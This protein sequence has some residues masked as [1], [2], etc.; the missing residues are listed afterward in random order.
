MVYKQYTLHLPAIAPVSHVVHG[1]VRHVFSPDSAEIQDERETVHLNVLVTT[2]Q[3][4][5]DRRRT[6]LLLYGEQ[7]AVFICHS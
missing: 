6:Y 7:L 1:P 2:G 3:T 4:S 5:N